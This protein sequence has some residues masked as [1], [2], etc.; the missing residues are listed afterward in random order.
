[1]RADVEFTKVEYVRITGA[2]DSVPIRIVHL[3]RVEATR[4]Y[5]IGVTIYGLFFVAASFA[6]H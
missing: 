6:A 3:A 2:F 5:T 1:M 4:I